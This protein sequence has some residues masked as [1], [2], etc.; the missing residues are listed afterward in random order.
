MDN[1]VVEPGMVLAHPETLTKKHHRRSAVEIAAGK[2]N[3]DQNFDLTQINNDVCEQIAGNTR[4][5][6]FLAKLIRWYR[7]TRVRRNGHKWVTLTHAEWAEKTA[8]T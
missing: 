7:Y 6:K 8:L 4:A 2:A 5:G 1:T 3:V